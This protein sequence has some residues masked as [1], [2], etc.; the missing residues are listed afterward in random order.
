MVLQQYVV[1]LKRKIH[2]LK[3]DHHHIFFWLLERKKP[4]RLKYILILLKL[5]NISYVPQLI[6]NYLSVVVGLEA[7]LISLPIVSLAFSQTGTL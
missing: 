1:L 4:K 2:F 7:E 6:T 3:L 5:L